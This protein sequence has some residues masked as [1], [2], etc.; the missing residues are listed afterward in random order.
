MQPKLWSTGSYLA[1]EIMFCKIQYNVDTVFSALVILLCLT[2]DNFTCNR[3]LR[4]LKKNENR[5]R[6]KNTD[7]TDI[8]VFFRDCI[9]PNFMQIRLI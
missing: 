2:A 9:L 6:K 3:L 7:N 4:Y 8:S 5:Y 1:E